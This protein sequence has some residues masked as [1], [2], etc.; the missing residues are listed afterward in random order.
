MCLTKV[1]VDRNDYSGH[2]VIGRN[3]LGID[4]ERTSSSS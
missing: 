1:E 3:F 4:A 2:W